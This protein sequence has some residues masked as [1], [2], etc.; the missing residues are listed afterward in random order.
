ML[1]IYT[2][3]YLLCYILTNYIALIEIDSK[4]S[5]FDECVQSAAYD[6]WRGANVAC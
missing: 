4:D 6:I 5:V 2:Y 1:Y 3:I